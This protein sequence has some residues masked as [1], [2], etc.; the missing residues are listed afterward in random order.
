[1]SSDT[2]L[3]AT[4]STHAKVD[5]CSRYCFLEPLINPPL[6]FIWISFLPRNLIKEASSKHLKSLTDIVK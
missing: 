6:V 2:S 1:M 5:A 4:T 3:K